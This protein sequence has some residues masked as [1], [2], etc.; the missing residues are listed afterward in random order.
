MNIKIPDDVVEKYKKARELV[1]SG[2]EKALAV[3]LGTSNGVKYRITMRKGGRGIIHTLEMMEENS[4]IP[5]VRIDLL[6]NWQAVIDSADYVLSNMGM[7]DFREVAK[8]I[9]EHLSDRPRS[10]GAKEI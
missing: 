4:T 2:K 10:Q 6:G 5:A 8:F 3:V 9:L 7:E 1:E